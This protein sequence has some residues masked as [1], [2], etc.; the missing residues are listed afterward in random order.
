MTDWLTSILFFHHADLDLTVSSSVFV[1]LPYIDPLWKRHGRGKKIERAALRVSIFPLL[2]PF[3]F[4]IIQLHHNRKKAFYSR[5][6]LISYFF[7][8]K[9]TCWQGFHFIR[10]VR[11]LKW[12]E[13]HGDKVH[14]KWNEMKCYSFFNKR[15]EMK[16]NEIILHEWPWNEVK[17]SEIHEIHEIQW[18]QTVT[19]NKKDLFNSIKSQSL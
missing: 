2:L 4:W 1:S 5:N 18:N 14:M 9:S 6:Y 11:E 7:F 8:P 19:T 17:W 16:T 3:S 10:K 12:G 13:G 15:R